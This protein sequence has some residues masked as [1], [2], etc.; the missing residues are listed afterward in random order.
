MS[1]P[2]SASMRRGV[3]RACSRPARPSCSPAR[4]SPRRGCS[5][6]TGV[7][8]SGPSPQRIEVNVTA[9]ELAPGA[10]LWGLEIRAL[11]ARD[12]AEGTL[13]VTIPDAPEIVAAREEA[14]K[15]PPPP[16]PPGLGRG[17]GAEDGAVVGRTVGAGVGFDG[18][19]FEGCGFD[20][21]RPGR[22]AERRNRRTEVE[23]QCLELATHIGN[24]QTIPGVVVAGKIASDT[25]RSTRGINVNTVAPCQAP[26]LCPKKSR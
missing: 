19:G 4:C 3:S 22:E 16:P 12:R 24:M 17:V 11:A 21:G 14:A 6:R 10:L 18:C 13:T 23:T 9:D 20:G 15:P 2:R 26:P 7:R 25:A 5:S 1:L 8:R